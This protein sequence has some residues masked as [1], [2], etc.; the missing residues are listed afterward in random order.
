MGGLIYGRLLLK[1]TR[2]VSKGGGFLGAVELA[3]K[4]E[5]LRG[6]IA[7]RRRENKCGALRLGEV[8]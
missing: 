3:K 4:K 7:R 8:R 6:E 5:L 2:T 1:A